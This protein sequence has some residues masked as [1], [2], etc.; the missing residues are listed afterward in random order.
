MNER[1]L[2][3]PWRLS[4]L[5]L[6]AGGLALGCGEPDRRHLAGTGRPITNGSP[7]TDP[8][9]MATVALTDGPG[10]GFFCSGTLITS[11]VVL[12]A[13]HC[14]EDYW[15]NPVDPTDIQIF[16]GDDVNAG[17]TY[18][19]VSEGLQHPNW[20]RN[21]LVGDIALLRLSATAPAGITPIPHLPADL[22]LGAADEGVAQVDFSGFGAT[23]TGASGEK[24]HV[25][26]TIDLV[27]DAAAGC[28]N[29][30]SQ[31]TFGYDQDPGGPCSGDS[32]GPAYLLRN[33][34]EYVA[35][36]TSYG[37][38]YCTSAGASTTVDRYA[39]WIDAF[40]GNVVVEDCSNGVDDDED[41]LT[42]CDDDD[43]AGHPDCLGPSACAE[44]DPATC[45]SEITSTTV[46]GAMNFSS[47]SCLQGTEDGPEVAYQVIAPEGAQVNVTMQPGAGGDLDLFLLAGDADDC[48]PDQCLDGSVESGQNPEQI[49]FVMPADAVYLVIETYDQPTSFNMSLSCGDSE[50]CDNGVDDD[51][52]GAVDC[53][54][55]D[56]AQDPACA[57]TTAC[58]L[59]DD[60]ACGQAVSGSTAN[61]VDLYTTYSCLQGY[62]WDGPELAFWI[63]A[64]A[65]TDAVARLSHGDNSDLDLFLLPAAGEGCDPDACIDASYNEVPPERITFTVP[66]GG[67]FLVVDTWQG[68][69]SFS[70]SLECSGGGENCTN[71]VDD[72]GDG[73]VDCD[74][75]DCRNH[76]DCQIAPEDCTNGA[77]DD[78]DGLVDCDDPECDDHPS[79][80]PVEDCSNG[81]DDDGDGDADCDDADCSGHPDCQPDPED[82]SNGIDDDGDGLID[83][84]DGDCGGDP[85]CQPDPED[86]SNGVDDD[87]DGLVDCDDGE[88][89]D[90]PACQQPDEDCDNGVDDDGDGAVDCDDADCVNHPACQTSPEDCDNGIDDDGD[91]D[92]DCDDLDCG[93]DPACQPEDEICDNGSDDDGDGRTDCDDPD[94]RDHPA[95]QTAEVCDNDIDDDGDGR[96]DCADIDDCASDPA[97]MLPDDSDGGCGCAA[98]GSRGAPA[99]GLALLLLLLG[100]ALIRR[101]S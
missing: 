56:C 78:G 14:L 39:A 43:C 53:S 22:G 65:G 54:D 6:L 67:A 89:A 48:D 31:Y 1:I 90:D 7:D 59:A 32:G 12:T 52:D 3:N 95:C 92:V 10:T 82:C 4:I 37:D 76:P 17:G 79:C 80:Q 47:Y 41:G 21:Q 35:G 63:D 97:C 99:G 16:F 85:A 93:A 2:G 46:G 84:E 100:A 87:G 25:E 73:L 57:G 98:G 19:A 13:A 42:D 9:H 64:A 61:G 26:N 23:E 34:T 68:T 11:S 74:D 55:P 30:L 33:G 75:S 70:L 62:T 27:C 96:T 49:S 81:I 24:L 15:G 60:I 5:F 36:V 51:G 83:C 20:D 77:D 58:V 91:G 29:W 28:S 88:C 45:G 101:R 66:A 50:V 40:L 8:A 44:A 38:R 86:C 18:R 69:S 94:C 72:D 71:G